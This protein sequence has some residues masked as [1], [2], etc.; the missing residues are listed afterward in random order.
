MLLYRGEKNGELLS[1]PARSA[2]GRN[3]RLL[4]AA[5]KRPARSCQC[6]GSDGKR[7]QVSQGGGAG[8]ATGKRKQQGSDPP[9]RPNST[10][11]VRAKEAVQPPRHL[12]KLPSSSHTSEIHTRKRLQ[13]RITDDPGARAPPSTPDIRMGR[14]CG[15]GGHG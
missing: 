14:G 11:L 1:S 15:G 4:Q 2:L 3:H 5:A 10:I 8:L 12:P 7:A 6:A 13:G 9:G